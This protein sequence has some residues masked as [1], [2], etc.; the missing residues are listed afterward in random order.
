MREGRGRAYPAID[1]MASELAYLAELRA[2]AG[3]L[4]GDL[5]DE[6]LSTELHGH[7]IGGLLDHMIQAE[8]Y[9]VAQVAGAAEP[10]LVSSCDEIERFTRDA[11]GGLDLGTQVSVGPFTGV[12]Q[13]L[14]HLHWH[15]TYHSAQIGLVR[16]A[17]G[18]EYRW[19]FQ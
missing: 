3:D 1:G 17:L 18:Y 2:R 19:T 11:L 8:L 12:G 6:A 13:V 14:R 16:K 7:S 5:P 10:S 15:W 9:W 4:V